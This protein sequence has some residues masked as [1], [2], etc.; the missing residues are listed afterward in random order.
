MAE[1]SSHKNTKT[2]GLHGSKT[3]V[4]ISGKRRLDA[5]S[6]KIAREVERSNGEKSLVED[7]AAF[8]EIT[9]RRQNNQRKK[10][11]T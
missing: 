7:S 3:E 1:T 4:P 8:C 10:I 9:N 2:R 5:S 11:R 6:P